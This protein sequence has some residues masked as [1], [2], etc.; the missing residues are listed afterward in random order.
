MSQDVLYKA[1]DMISVSQD[2]FTDIQNSLLPL[3]N[4]SSAIRVSMLTIPP[5]SEPAHDAPS[6]THIAQL[7]SATESLTS[8]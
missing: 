3:R 2:M 7:I 1:P 4:L 5:T 8:G 6:H